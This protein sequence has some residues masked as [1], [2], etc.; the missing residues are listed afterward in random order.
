MEGGPSWKIR[1]RGLSNALEDRDDLISIYSAAN[2]R[3]RFSICDYSVGVIKC[4]SPRPASGVI[5]A[6]ARTLG[7]DVL[8]LNLKT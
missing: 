6:Y 8:G 2:M 5:L 1:L 7:L 4:V 3:S